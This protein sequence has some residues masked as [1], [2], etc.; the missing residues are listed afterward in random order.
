MKIKQISK[1]ITLMKLILFSLITNLPFSAFSTNIILKPIEGKISELTIKK[2]KL[3]KGFVKYSKC[4]YNPN[5]LEKDSF[6]INLLENEKLICYKT[7][8]VKRNI[9][10]FSWYGKADDKITDIIFTI[11]NGEMSA[12]ISNNIFNYYVTSFN[13]ELMLIKFDEYKAL[14]IGCG[15]N[16][17][18]SSESDQIYNLKRG[19]VNN[20]IPGNFSCKLRIAVFYTQKAKNGSN[21]ILLTIQQSV[22]QLNVA[23]MNS[24]INVEAELACTNET[25]DVESGFSD[26]DRNAI[27]NQNDGKFDNFKE[28]S[29]QCGAD[30]FVLLYERDIYSNDFG[31]AGAIKSCKNRAFALVDYESS[32]LRATFTHEI[33]HIF[34]C[35]HNLK[36][37]PSELPYKY[38]HAIC[39]SSVGVAN[40][41]MTIMGIL[42]SCELTPNR[43]LHFSNPDVN[44]GPL[45]ISTGGVIYGNNARVIIENIENV[46]SFRNNF[47]TKYI[48]Q[49]NVNSS[50][51]LYH[52]NKIKTNGNL[53]INNQRIY[54]IM[55]GNEIEI[56]SNFETADD[57]NL[58]IEIVEKCGMPDNSK[59]NYDT[60]AFTSDS[61][62]REII[63]NIQMK[64]SISP[65]PF[66]S[67]FNINSNI[68]I[69][70]IE[71]FN[72][73]GTKVMLK[74]VLKLK[75][76]T[77]D[78]SS[79]INGIYFIKITNHLNQ[80][81]TN[82]IIKI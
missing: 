16:N 29:D 42:G 80:S 60:V 3:E 43:I 46:I 81:L 65:N 72:V 62:I 21:N 71:V 14:R 5:L 11:V 76:L 19:D 67:I 38:G 30:I 36:T 7:K 10:N 64:I 28:K 34:G 79:F 54:G 25:Y 74:D 32:V 45:G 24:N 33:G 70:K 78:L 23:F 66:S 20:Q 37:D 58:I 56:S 59:C 44:Y 6:E 75:S 1:T 52:P 31:V 49:V 40:N 53:F 69:L 73:F 47:K 26:E 8:T 57:A 18:N 13:N 35:R 12:I 41:F 15:M 55:A 51:V 4:Q 50:N 61:L 68:D 48:D 27:L 17:I 22:D 82:K 2:L 63:E 77:I 39:Y 9:N